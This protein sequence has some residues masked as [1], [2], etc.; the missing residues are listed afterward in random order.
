MKRMIAAALFCTLASAAQAQDK[1]ASIAGNWHIQ[2]DVM[3]NGAD[4]NCTVAQDDKTLSGTCDTLGELKGIV[5][6][7]TYT[8]G[9]RGGQSALNFTGKLKDGALVGTVDVLDYSVQGDFK[10]TMAK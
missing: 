8:W 1:P 6:G 5:T 2:I 7:D 3:G 10:G 9:T 4:F